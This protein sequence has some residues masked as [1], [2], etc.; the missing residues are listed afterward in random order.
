MPDVVRRVSAFLNYAIYLGKSLLD[1]LVFP[2]IHG[3]IG[4]D[5]GHPLVNGFEQAGVVFLHENAEVVFGEGLIDERGG[6]LGV[7]L[8]VA[9]GFHG[10]G[11]HD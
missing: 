4:F 8:G 10:F 5:G 6:Y 7:V 1:V 9:A 11:D 3:A 2:L